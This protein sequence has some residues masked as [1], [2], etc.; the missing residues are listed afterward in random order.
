M[1]T[2]GRPALRAS[3]L[4]PAVFG[5]SAEGQPLMDCP[6]CG[7][8]QPLFRKMIS[9]HRP[10]GRRCLGSGQELV[11]DMPGEQWRIRLLDNGRPAIYAS[12]LHPNL[13]SLVPGEPP[14]VV[15]VDCGRWCLLE[16]GML[17]SHFPDGAACRGGGQRIVFDLTAPQWRAR[18]TEAER[19]AARRHG[20]RVY[21]SPAPPVPPPVCHIRAA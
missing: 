8:R 18:L 2:N 10:H 14:T 6:D 17:R 4:P 15:C 12:R 16:H 11:I 9:A 3:E 13:I 20:S 7:E 19:D 21:V 1:R 5:L